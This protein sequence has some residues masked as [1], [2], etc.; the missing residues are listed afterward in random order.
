MIKRS[1]M[2]SIIRSVTGRSGIVAGVLALAACGNPTANPDYIP[3]VTEPT[4]YVVASDQADPVVA[5]IADKQTTTVTLKLT[6]TP[7]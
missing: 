5:H 7:S 3:A 6:K 2:R 1:R 4:G